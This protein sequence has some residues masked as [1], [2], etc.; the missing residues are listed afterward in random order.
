M[1]L[2]SLRKL[3]KEGITKEHSVKQMQ[4]SNCKKRAYRVCHCSKRNRHSF[5]SE[6][7]QFQK[8][9]LEELIDKDFRQIV[10][11]NVPKTQKNTQ[12]YKINLIPHPLFFLFPN[13]LSHRGGPGWPLRRLKDRWTEGRTDE[14]PDSSCMVQDFVPLW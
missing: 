2:Y 10:W 5:A 11:K 4:S 1:T 3:A 14:R 8:K 6:K 9:S 12:F 7:D 13:G